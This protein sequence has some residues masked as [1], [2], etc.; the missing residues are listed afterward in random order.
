[1]L[2]KHKTAVLGV[3]FPAVEHFLGDYLASLEKQTQKDFDLILINDG[4]NNFNKFKSKYT[5][6]IKELKH[7]ASAAKIREFGINY[8]RNEGYKYIIFTDTDDFFSDNRIEKSIELLK[9]NDIVVNDLTTVSYDCNILES[10]YLSR[11]L[12]NLTTINY[13]FINDKNIFGF[14]NTALKLELLTKKI[15]FNTKL[16][17]VDWFFFST[18]L[19]AGYE[20]IFCNEAMTFYRI[21]ENNIVGL[22]SDI[23]MQKIEKGINVKMC[24]YKALS[25]FDSK[26][27]NLYLKL[28]DL[29][30]HLL[31]NEYKQIYFNSIKTLDMKTP[32]WWEEIKMP[33]E[34]GL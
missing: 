9:F 2:K 22:S 1:M 6:N 21:H 12:N 24:H 20:G 8:I 13:D 4:L 26:Y 10:S 27:I 31:N 23:S 15:V 7:T 5:L 29:K 25:K 17:A 14:S 34:I 11:R 32:F 28:V 18:L 19:R 16:V 30:K 3:I 33:E